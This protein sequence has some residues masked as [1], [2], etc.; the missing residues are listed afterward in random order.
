[1]EYDLAFKLLLTLSFVI[2][3]VAL[4]LKLLVE[5]YLWWVEVRE[6]IKIV[7]EQRMQEQDYEEDE[8]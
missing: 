3:S 2:V 8:Q 5:T 6:G 1:M 7:R 4:T